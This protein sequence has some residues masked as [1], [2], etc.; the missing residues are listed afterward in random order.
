MPEGQELNMYQMNYD[1][2]TNYNCGKQPH[3]E[4]PVQA[5]MSTFK[6][7]LSEVI[8]SVEST[9]TKLE[10]ET[11]WYNIEIKSTPGN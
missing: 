3:Q 7:L 2:I 4:F 5:K 10:V 1:E 9:V 11:V 6:P 8:S